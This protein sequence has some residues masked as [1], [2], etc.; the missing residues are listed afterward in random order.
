EDTGTFEE[1]HGG[2]R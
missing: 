2:V 1:G